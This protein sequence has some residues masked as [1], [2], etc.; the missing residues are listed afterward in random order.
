MPQSTPLSIVS[1]SRE[2]LAHR[3]ADRVEHVLPHKSLRLGQKKSEKCK[4]ILQSQRTRNGDTDQVTVCNQDGSLT[5]T[6]ATPEIL[7]LW[8]G[9]RAM[10]FAEAH[11]TETGIDVDHAVADPRW[12][13]SSHP[14]GDSPN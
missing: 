4:M 1:A 6:G 12:P 11:L 7:G 8:L 9:S 10:V 13:P 5:W 2:Q 14:Q 3:N